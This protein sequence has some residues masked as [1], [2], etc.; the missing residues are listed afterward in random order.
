[1]T[2]RRTDMTKVTVDVRNFVNAT[3]NESTGFVTIAGF[4]GAL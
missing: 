3:K 2:D 4:I 1:M